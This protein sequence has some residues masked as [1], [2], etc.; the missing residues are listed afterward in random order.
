MLPGQ[1]RIAVAIGP[2]AGTV[3][4]DTTDV[5]PTANPVGAAEYL[6]DSLAAGAV[7]RAPF[8]R[9]AQ[10]LLIRIPAEDLD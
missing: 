4:S 5:P 9:G 1:V 2:L 10:I 6:V 8:L 3:I 7:S